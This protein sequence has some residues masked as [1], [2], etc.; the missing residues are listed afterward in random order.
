MNSWNIP[1]KDRI[2]LAWELRRDIHAHPELGLQETRTSAIVAD[3]FRKL[4]LDVRTGYAKTGVLGILKGGRPGPVVAMRGDMDALPWD[5]EIDVG[6]PEYY[7]QDMDTGKIKLYPVPESPGTLKLTVWRTQ[8][9]PLVWATHQA[10][11]PEIPTFHHG[12]LL[13]YVKFLAWCKQDAEAVDPG[14]AA[15]SFQLFEAA[16][17]EKPNAREMEARRVQYVKRVVA[18][19]M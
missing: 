5:W 15:Q 1:E 13:E 19:F 11:V 12:D 18:R 7:L 4:G 3:Y 10:V 17:G 8:L 16:F 9:T 14:R 2:T 6:T